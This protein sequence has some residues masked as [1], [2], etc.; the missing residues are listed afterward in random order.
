M[1]LLQ[2][3]IRFQMLDYWCGG[4]FLSALL[5]QMN[6]YHCIPVNW[7]S[8]NCFVQVQIYRVWLSI[9]QRTNRVSVISVVLS[10][11]FTITVLNDMNMFNWLDLSLRDCNTCLNCLTAEVFDVET[12]EI[13]NNT[14]NNMQMPRVEYETITIDDY[15]MYSC[16]ISKYCTQILPMCTS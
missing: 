1:F 6:L 5:K 10:S 9:A 13:V 14:Y 2:R 11:Y 4:L 7:F 16:G 3:R 8:L 12:N 15:S